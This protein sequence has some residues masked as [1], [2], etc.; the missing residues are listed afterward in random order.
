MKI[1]S[2][3]QNRH[4]SITNKIEQYVAETYD[5]WRVNIFHKIFGNQ[6]GL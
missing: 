2:L 6:S 4:F 1:T 5:T 3:T